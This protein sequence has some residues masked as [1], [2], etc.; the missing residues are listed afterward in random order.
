MDNQKPTVKKPPAQK[1]TASATPPARKDPM[2]D[3]RALGNDLKNKFL[4]WAKN[5]EKFKDIL[6]NNYTLGRDHLVRGNVND[7]IMRFKF[8]LWL[9]P[10]Y[11]DTWYYLGCSYLADSNIRSARDAFTKALK[12]HPESIEA[13]YMLAITM[14]KAM[15][16]AELPKVIPQDLLLQQFEDLAPSYTT[17]QIGTF[18][19]EGH[20]QLANA[21]RAGLVQ[22][23]M[24]HIILEVGVGTGLCGPLLRD[25]ASHITGVD[26]SPAMLAEAVKVVDDRGSKIYDALICREAVA[27]MTDGPDSSY[28]IVMG[29]GLVSYLGDLQPFF[30]QA[31]RILKSGGIL[32]F[33]ADKFD[34]TGFLFDPETGRFRFAQAYLNDLAARFGLKEFR[35][36][37][38]AIYPESAGWLCVYRK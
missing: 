9:D 29:A 14:G 31:A 11:R 16:K 19:Y 8:V 25:A 33:T 23:R 30:E 22:G 15:P 21:V 37:E 28:D 7:A 5:F 36:R 13:R 35:S 12:M 17:D 27:F 4:G 26:I 24:D 2:A 20:T 6:K 3:M 38:A 18:K 10:K 34:G 32:A 1:N